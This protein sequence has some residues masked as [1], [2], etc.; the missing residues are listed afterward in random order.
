[1]DRRDSIKTLLLGSI[2]SSFF[3]SGCSFSEDHNRPKL[4]D[5]YDFSSYGRTPE[6]AAHDRKIFTDNF[7]SSHEIETVAELCDLIL[8]ATNT[9]GSASEAHVPEFIDFIVKEMPNHQ[10]PLR[11]GIKWVDNHSESKFGIDFI[12]LN[13]HQQT[14]IL[15]EI[16]YPD[17]AADEHKE[18][19][20]FFTLM[21]NLTLTGYY[22]SEMGFKDLGYVGNT[23]NNW[24]GVPDEVLAEHGLSYEIGWEEKFINPDTRFEIAEW[25]ADGNLLNN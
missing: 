8:P 17:K 23:P 14:V 9:A 24:D 1:M 6:E 25:D 10:D 4:Q 20:E 19:V 16:A 21:R 22:T 3:L 5:L 2:G 12:S 11:A 7:F 13:A 18:G 15:D